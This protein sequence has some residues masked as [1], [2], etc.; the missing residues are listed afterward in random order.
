MHSDGIQLSGA[1]NKINALKEG[2]GYKYLGVME[3]NELLHDQ[4]KE[5]I[6]KRYLR[7]LK[8]LRLR[9]PD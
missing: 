2:E 4:M 1:D 9:D 6:D 3:V 8:K 5:K 7:S